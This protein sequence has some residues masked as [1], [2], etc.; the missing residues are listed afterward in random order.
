MLGS[1]LRREDEMYV[2]P[3]ELI[4]EILVRL[5]VFALLRFRTSECIAAE[6]EVWRHQNLLLIHEEEDQKKQSSADDSYSASCLRH[7]KLPHVDTDS[8]L[9]CKGSCNGI[10]WFDGLNGRLTRLCN[11]IT[12]E[13]FE[14][15]YETSLFGDK[16]RFHTAASGFGF[17]E[18][19]NDYKYISIVKESTPYPIKQFAAQIYKL[20]TNSWSVIEKQ[21]DHNGFDLNSITSF[22]GFTGGVLFNGSLHWRNHS[23]T[24]PGRVIQFLILT[25]DLHTETF[26]SIGVHHQINYHYTLGR[27]GVL[28]NDPRRTWKLTVLGD[29]LAIVITNYPTIAG[30]MLFDV[31]VMKEYEN[32]ES[33]TK[34]CS[35]GPFSHQPCL[36]LL[37]CWHDDEL[38]ALTDDDNRDL[39]SC[40]L[41]LKNGPEEEEDEQVITTFDIGCKHV[42]SK[43]C[44]QAVIFQPSFVSIGGGRRN[45]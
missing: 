20:S 6:E 23:H 17:D 33:W 27:D 40:K 45:L 19:T 10:L 29:C 3:E 1:K 38:L 7:L 35:V 8:L 41:P 36:C 2:W 44:V 18:F 15:P 13:Y 14:L 32:Q 21:H 4:V 24:N 5:P 26:G 22:P 42:K 28:R 43:F 31:W 9:G 16:E 30:K 34:R 25:F 11:P 37:T 12:Q 39:V